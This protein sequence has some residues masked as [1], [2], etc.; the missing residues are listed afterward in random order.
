[1]A[2]LSDETEWIFRSGA[3]L[4]PAPNVSAKASVRCSPGLPSG[5][6][7]SDAGGI[8]SLWPSEQRR[9]QKVS[10]VLSDYAKPSYPPHICMCRHTSTI[11]NPAIYPPMRIFNFHGI[12]SS[13]TTFPPSISQLHH[14][15]RFR[16][17]SISQGILTTPAKTFIR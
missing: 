17:E 6:H 11:M 16:E 5:R 1:M 7:G 12:R 8:S 4:Q 2:E 15:I 9:E 10:S 3:G 14:Q 13:Q